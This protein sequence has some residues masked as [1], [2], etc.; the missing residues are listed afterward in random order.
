MLLIKNKLPPPPWYAKYR[1]LNV[2][3]TEEFIENS[4]REDLRLMIELKV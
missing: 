2:A 3:V 1:Y 4:W